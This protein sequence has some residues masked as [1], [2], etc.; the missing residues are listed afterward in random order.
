MLP[1]EALFYPPRNPLKIAKYMAIPHDSLFLEPLP[2]VNQLP[3]LK[4]RLEVQEKLPDHPSV[5]QIYPEL[6]SLSAFR[7]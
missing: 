6:D 4:M 2:P 3:K 7:H 1:I 5:A